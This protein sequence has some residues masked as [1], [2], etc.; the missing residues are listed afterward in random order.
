MVTQIVILS[1]LLGFQVVSFVLAWKA[2]KNSPV[3][4]FQ[5]MEGLGLW[6]SDLETRHESLVASHKKLNSRYAMAKAREARGH[7]EKNNSSDS[8]SLAQL[9]GESDAEWKSRMRRKIAAGELR[10]VD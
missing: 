10:H 4:L 3:S 1:L 2:W 9:P 6:I 7:E 8:G 5:K